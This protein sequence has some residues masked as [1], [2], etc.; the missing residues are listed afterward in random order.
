[1]NQRALPYGRQWI[2]DEDVKAVLAC[3]RDDNLTQ[4]PRVEQ[5]E[6]ALCEA[7]GASHAAVV[8]NGTAALHLATLALGLG[9]GDVGITSPVTFVA[10]ANAIRYAGGRVALADVDPATGLI[11]PQSVEALVPQLRAQGLRPRLLIPVDFAGQ[12]ADLPALNALAR[13]NDM[14]LLQD[15]AHSLGATLDVDGQA[16]RI[17]GHSLADA[18]ILSFHPVKHI[19][20]GEGGALLSPHADVHGRVQDLRSHGIHKRTGEFARSVDEAY[21]GPWYYEQA[22]LGFNYRLPDLNCSLGLSQLAKLER[23]V[24]RRRALA[25]AYDSALSQESFKS[26]LEPLAQIPDRRSSYHLY[27]VRLLPTK[28]ESLLGLAQRRKDLF[29]S[30][31]AAGILAQVHYIPVHWQPEQRDAILPEGGLPGAD[32]FY[33]SCLSLP[34]FPAMTDAD[35]DLVIA[36]LVKGRPPAVRPVPGRS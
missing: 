34:M 30:L 14:R 35:V 5:F 4:G 21:V 25:A 11:A 18:T 31:H 29:L 32:L 8:S 27:V 26:W 10:S 17:A 19:T 1:M 2:D 28:G 22:R 13:A 9:P 3:L 36:A 20:T 15:A 6:A 24:Q 23:F 33:A 12:P 16:C 7:T